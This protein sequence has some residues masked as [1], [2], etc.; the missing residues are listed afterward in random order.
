V[1]LA[2]WNT[3]FTKPVGHAF[4]SVPGIS[5]F[6]GSSVDVVARLAA[7]QAD[8]A[9]VPAD[10]ALTASDDVDILPAVAVSMWQAESSRLVLPSG[11]SSPVLSLLTGPE[12][13]YMTLLA[14]IVLKEHYGKQVLVLDAGEFQ[15]HPSWMPAVVAEGEGDPFEM[16]LVQEWSEMAH[17][18][19]VAALFITR[20]GQATGEVIRTV[21]DVVCAFD[22]KRDDRERNRV[23]LRLDDLTVASLSELADYLFYYEMTPEIQGVTFASLDDEEEETHP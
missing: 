15:L 1:R 4:D 23:R 12:S 13:L 10:H 19:L 2:I 6:Q 7:D 21:R 9:L 3:P 14:R 5:V 16:D 11:L 20:K 17:Y 8:V 18:P 22:D